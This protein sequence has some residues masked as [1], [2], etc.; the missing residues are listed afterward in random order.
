MFGE[1]GSEH[2]RCD[3]VVLR[4]DFDTEASVNSSGKAVIQPQS[5]NRR[6]SAAKEFF[7]RVKT[8]LAT[9]ALSPRNRA[10]KVEP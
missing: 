2:T 4:V 7:P 9:T 1:H 6:S 10:V 3:K 5:E 8:T